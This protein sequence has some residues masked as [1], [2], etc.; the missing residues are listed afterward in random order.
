MLSAISPW[1]LASIA[2]NRP[3]ADELFVDGITLLT[4][5]PFADRFG[6]RRMRK[7]GIP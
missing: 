5:Q 7:D 4:T 3:A 1:L 6:H 2:G